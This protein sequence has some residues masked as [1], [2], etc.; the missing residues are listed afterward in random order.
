MSKKKETLYKVEDVENCENTV[1]LDVPDIVYVS[2]KGKSYYPRKT[3]LATIPLPLETAD[4]KGYKP[5]KAYQEFVKGIYSEYK[6]KSN[7]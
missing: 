4:Q 7:A 2:K 5:S 1:I 3:A 6:S